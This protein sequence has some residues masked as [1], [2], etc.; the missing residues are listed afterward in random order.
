MSLAIISADQVQ[1]QI[2]ERIS[3]ALRH[4]PYL[5]ARNLRFESREGHVTL[6]GRVSSWY[7]K[8]MAQES[9]MRVDGVDRV[10]NQ[11]EVCWI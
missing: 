1:M 10:E 11:L 2:D 8:Q 4:N 7:Q 9:L 5:Q 6:H 3:S